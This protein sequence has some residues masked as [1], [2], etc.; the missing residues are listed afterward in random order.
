MSRKPQPISNLQPAR[1]AHP[2]IEPASPRDTL[3]RVAHVIELLKELNLA[4]GLSPSARAG[5]FWVHGMLAD[6]VKHVSDELK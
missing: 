6:A 2:L 3:D 4:E 1:P 5:L